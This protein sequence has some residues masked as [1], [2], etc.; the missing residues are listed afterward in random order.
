VEFADPDADADAH[1]NEHANED[2]DADPDADPDADADTDADP[3][4]DA[5]RDDD[6]AFRGAVRDG[7][8]GATVNAAAVQK[9]LAG[10]IQRA[11]DL[12]PV[13]NLM[14]RHMMASIRT[15]F[16]VGGRPVPWASL[17]NVH[18]LPKGSRSKKYRAEG[19]A[20]QGGPLVLTGDLRRSIGF[21]PESK[22]LVV[23]D[24][25]SRDAVKAPVHQYG[26]DS[27][28]RGHN[29]HI[30]KRPYLFFQKEDRAYF[31]D[32]VSGFIRLGSAS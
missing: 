18:V 5:H 21:T 22:D 10:M 30:P 29:V 32:L 6:A 1:E 12:T 24:R 3:D 20:R 27:A 11:G 14:G 7:M 4:E 8:I 31:H 16:D 9:R 17:K 19:R 2:I 13:M 15:T 23:W 25:P 28:G 26:T